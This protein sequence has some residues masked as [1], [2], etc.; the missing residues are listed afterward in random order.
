MCWTFYVTHSFDHECRVVLMHTYMQVYIQ[1]IELYNISNLI[2]GLWKKIPQIFM[3]HF[4]VPRNVL[5]CTCPKNY[6]L[7]I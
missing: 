4:S 7:T 6:I 3:S 2:D 1:I 5:Q